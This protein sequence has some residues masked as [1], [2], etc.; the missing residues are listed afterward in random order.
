MILN[1]VKTIADNIDDF[2][3]VSNGIS[4]LKKAVLTLA[5]SR[6]LVP[7][8]KKEGYTK[9]LGEIC[10]IYQPKTIS[11]KELI[12][13]GKYAVFGANGII[14]RYNKYNHEEPQLLI[15]CRGATCGSV[16]ISEPKSW[17]NG[18]AMVIKPKDHSINLKYLEY[19]FRGGLD[20]SKIITGTAQPQITRTNLAPVEISYPVSKDEQNRIVKKI[21]E[22]IKQL[23]KLEIR[24]NER[25]EIR[26]RL[27]RSAMQSLGKGESKIALK[28]LVEL[29]KK[30]EDIKELE[31][32]I[33]TLAV[34]G[35]LIPQDK[36]EWTGEEP[37]SQI[38]KELKNSIV[39]Q[40]QRKKIV[41][42]ITPEEIPFSIPKSWKWV[43][44]G[45]VCDAQGG[46]QP[47]KSKFM[48]EETPNYIRFLQIRD[49][50]S[51]NN[52]TYIPVD[53]KN[54]ICEVGD[55]LIGRYGASVGKVLTGKAGAYNVAIMKTFPNLTILDKKYFYYFLLS[56]Y[57]QSWFR[58]LTRAAQA[59]FNKDDLYPRPLP[60]PPIVEQKRIVKKVEEVM[61]LINRLRDI[62]DDNKI[63]SKGRPKK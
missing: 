39:K 28:Q 52:L 26:S 5:M 25:D 19:I 2:I 3:E 23:D 59:G 46:S 24:K 12:E 17:I 61:V 58:S 63:G 27:T 40:K 54:K 38:Q 48:Y 8:D 11:T 14:G 18:N 30:P 34:S 56:N 21:E 10:E 22:V 55:I 13:N 20:L 4:Q 1:D 60:L 33:L 41:E 42:A 37:F 29:V 51:D 9:K 50:S 47:P 44:F 35:K 57:M 6:K 36:R 15:T 32:A 45:D 62:V 53:A 49:F 43:R 16:N 31:D 7:Q